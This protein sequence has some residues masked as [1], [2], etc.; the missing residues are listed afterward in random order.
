MQCYQR[1]GHGDDD[2]Y[3]AVKYAKSS[4][5]FEKN[6]GYYRY[7]PSVLSLHFEESQSEATLFRIKEYGP[8]PNA[9]LDLRIG[10]AVTYYREYVELGPRVRGTVI[11]FKRSAFGREIKVQ[12]SRLEYDSDGPL[13]TE[14]KTDWIP[15]ESN[16]IM[17]P[18]WS[19]YNFMKMCEWK[20][21]LLKEQ[22]EH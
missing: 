15:A 14:G 3:L 18:S 9:D 20:E 2:K 21:Q 1:R 13:L 10:C 7:R 17:D 5:H 22:E 8:L 4:L 11:D 16:D 12:Y 19:E 6:M